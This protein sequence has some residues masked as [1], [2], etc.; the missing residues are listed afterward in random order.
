MRMSRYLAIGATLASVLAAAGALTADG[1][2][3]SDFT[4]LAGSAGPAVDESSPITLSN[5]VFEQ[6]SLAD[7]TTQLVGMPNTG[8]WDMITSNETGP[9]KGRFLF[10]V[11]EA[12]GGVQRHD[13][14]S[15]VTD[16]IWISPTPS[17]AI[18]FDPA[19]WTP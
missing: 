3:F 14:L 16:T 8:A 5:P 12:D 18:R 10:T 6:R 15:G 9:H 1:T 13:L 7:R 17:A 2:R 11:F 19:F 4:P